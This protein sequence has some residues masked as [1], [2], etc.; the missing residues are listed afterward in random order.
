M[1]RESIKRK[2]LQKLI[3]AEY[4][5]FKDHKKIKLGKVFR[6][7]TPDETGCDWS[8]S[9]NRDTGWELAAD[10]IRPFIISLRSTYMLGD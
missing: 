2:N 7:D 5:Q 1:K 9:I 4:K 10:H 3:K 8:I 6:L